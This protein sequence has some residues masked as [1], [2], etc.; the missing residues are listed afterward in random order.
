MDFFLDDIS[1][2]CQISVLKFA[3]QENICSKLSLLLRCFFNISLNYLSTHYL[4]NFDINNF[5]YLGGT[6]LNVK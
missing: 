5:L 3:N 1:N 4:K 6:I 2:I